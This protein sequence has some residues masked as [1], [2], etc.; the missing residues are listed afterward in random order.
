MY[1]ST[2]L[3]TFLLALVGPNGAGKSTLLKL[4]LGKISP[5]EGRL[6]R[7]MSL[8]LAEY[9]QHS[10]DLLDMKKSALDFFRERYASWNHES[11]WWRSQL[12][13]YGISGSMQTMEMGTLSDGQQSRIVFALLAFEKPHI[14]LLDE[15]VCWALWNPVRGF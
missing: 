14:L 15:P 1:P 2:V 8:K 12:G 10:A 4:M 9:N 13:R 7:N 5:T 3:T 11:D 6:G